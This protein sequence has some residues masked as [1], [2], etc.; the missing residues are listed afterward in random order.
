MAVY[1]SGYK[2]LAIS[3][4]GACVLLPIAGCAQRE[5]TIVNEKVELASYIG[6]YQ[7]TGDDAYNFFV[8]ERDNKL[9]IQNTWGLTEINIQADHSFEIEKW[10]LKGKIHDFDNGKFQGYTGTVDGV[11]YD[12][13]RIDVD[14]NDIGF[15]Y[16]KEGYASNFSQP[17]GTCDSDSYKL[18]NL[19]DNSHKPEKIEA[20]IAQIQ[21]KKYAWAEQDSLL[22]YQD[23]KLLVEEYFNGYRRQDPHQIQSVSKSLTSLLV[24]SLVTQGKITDV[25]TPIVKF[26]PEYKHWLQDQKATITLANFL[27]MAAGI[28]WDEWT[29]RYTD[30]NNIRGKEMESDDA[31]A[32]TLGLPM[33]NKPGEVFAYS[34]GYVSVV[35][36]VISNLSKQETAADY[37]KHGPLKTLCFNNAY[38]YKQKDGKTNTAGGG[39][40]RPIDM[41]KIGQLMLDGGEWQDKQLIDK[42]WIEDSLDRT[43]NP[44][45]SLYGYFWWHSDVFVLQSGK[46]YHYVH[47][48]G[49]GGQEIVIVKEL[50]LVVVTT[51]SNFESSGKV[52]EMLSQFIIPALI[53]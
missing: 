46:T 47:A 6:A 22:I 7:S 32:F 19:A 21:S 44:F 1:V 9:Y 11:D 45:N 48:S 13:K 16:Q 14:I 43:V 51:A 34:G 36:T 15:L 27:D 23:G 17:L 26:L 28:E 4:L 39:M 18:S 37:A 31:V 20:L 49:W 42:Q 3:L 35:G 40:M 25:N 33:N 8:V 52:G 41:L 29:L 24:G 53:E 5:G 30:P 12:Y 50:G 2:K 10:G 38:W